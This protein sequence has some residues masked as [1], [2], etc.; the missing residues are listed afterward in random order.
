MFAPLL[1]AVRADIDRQ[2]GWAEGEIRRHVRFAALSGALGGVA[3]L[4]S[5]GALVVGL[6]A[7]HVWLETR[8]GALASRPSNCRRKR[9]S[10][11]SLPYASR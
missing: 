7:L 6:I 9:S 3:A 8:I 1:G 11:T 2:V 5:V 4:A 10:R